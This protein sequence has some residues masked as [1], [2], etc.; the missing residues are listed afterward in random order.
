MITVDDPDFQL[1][2]AK[3]VDNFGFEVIDCYGKVPADLKRKFTG[4]YYEFETRSNFFFVTA[5]AKQL[6]IA[7]LQ[8]LFVYLNHEYDDVSQ[9]RIRLVSTIGSRSN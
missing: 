4:D 3:L 2:A 9:V 6:E 1:K 5:Q 7:A 8:L